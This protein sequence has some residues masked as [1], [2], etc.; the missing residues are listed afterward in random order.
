MST[1]KEISLVEVNHIIRGWFRY[2]MSKWLIIALIALVFAVLG[3]LYAWS[4]KTE[5]TSELTFAAEGESKGGLGG[6]ASLAAT[7]GIDMSAGGGGA[8]EGDNL[9]ELIRSR[10][11]VENTFL[12]PVDINGKKELLVNYYIR[13]TDK[14]FA[15]DQ[16]VTFEVDQQP[17]N[18]KRDS[19]MDVFYQDALTRLNI[20]RVDKKLTI[21]SATFR[22]E[23]ELFAKLFL[24]N[25]VNNVIDYY[26][27]YKSL[28]GKQNLSILQ[29]QT[30]SVRRLISGGI[31]DV[32]ATN[33]LNVNPLRQIVRTGVQRKQVDVQVNSALY[34]EL[35]K[36]LELSKISLRKE[37]PLIQIID[38]PRLPLKKKKMGRLKGAII[39]GLAG[40]ILALLIFTIKRMLTP[41]VSDPKKSA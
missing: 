17:G 7:F 22:S 19:I 12:T 26:I 37:T 41:K 25:L 34:Q 23:D 18:R 40:G 21:V 36:N 9:I 39:F 32:A 10:R 1:D 20:G 24:E 35:V 6:Y 27:D 16:Q 38:S 13:A 4:Q 14:D 5:Y 2:I 8:F 28:K 31:V 11:I 15:K 3:V 29:R 30:D 33:D